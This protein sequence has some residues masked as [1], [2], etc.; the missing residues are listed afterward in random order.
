MSLS[1]EASP[2]TPELVVNGLR[3]VHERTTQSACPAKNTDF[4]RSFFLDRTARPR[5]PAARL[6]S[7][8]RFASGFTLVEVIVSLLLVGL[9]GTFSLFFLAD[10]I[11]GYFITQ[12]SADSAFK[13]QIALDRIRLELVDMEQLTASPVSNSLIQYTSTN[14]QLPGSRALKFLGSTLYLVVDGTD[15]PLVD[16]VSD[17]VLTVSWKNLDS[18]LANEVAYIDIGFTLETTLPYTI[19]VYPRNLVQNLP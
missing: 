13:A 12:K 4:G 7:R 9:V 14:G 2:E 18:D 8:A 19:R 6:D 15:Y 1:Y 3:A 10:G 11:E 5:R 17:E 16:G